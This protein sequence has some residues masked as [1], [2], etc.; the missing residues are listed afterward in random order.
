MNKRVWCVTIAFLAAG[1]GAS[2]CSVDER[3]YTAPSG[4]ASSGGEGSDACARALACDD[5]ES[6]KA[7]EPPSG[8]FSAAVDL[9]TVV[10]DTTRA[11]SGTQSVKLSTEAGE[12]FKAAVLQYSDSSTL[13]VSDNILYGRM[14]FWLESA[15]TEELHW[16]MITGRGLMPE[17]N[18]EV[19]YHIGGQFP[20]FDGEGQF[21]GSKLMANYDTPDSYDKP[22]VGPATSCW[23]HSDEKPAPLKEWTCAEWKFDGKNNGIELWLNG[24]DQAV[25]QV[26]ARGQGCVS[27]PDNYEWLAPPFTELFIGWESYDLD[28]PRTIWID[29]LAIGTE[30]L[31]CP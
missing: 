17:L 30:R 22:P 6:S 3:Q 26:N 1:T 28:G 18:Y 21:I 4:G 25:I 11:F 27:Q 23:E 16:S 20:V 24:S 29:D 5:F 10:V 19:V 7:Q 9:G 14:M 8:P 13:P 2:G 31:G 15:P 12:G